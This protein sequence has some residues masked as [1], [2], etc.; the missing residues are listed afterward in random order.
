[1]SLLCYLANKLSEGSNYDR[2]YQSACIFLASC[3]WVLMLLIVWILPDN[4]PVLL[5]EPIKVMGSIFFAPLYKMLFQMDLKS[6]LVMLLVENMV[7]N[8]RLSVFGDI[9]RSCSESRFSGLR[10]QIIF[11]TLYVAFT[12]K[13]FHQCYRM[14]FRLG[15]HFSY[16]ISLLLIHRW[17]D[18]SLPQKHSLFSTKG[19]PWFWAVWQ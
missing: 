2:I 3:F 12:M 17:R 1:M 18:V 11:R 19:C 10:R 15:N 6:Y 4:P 13:A 16:T 7:R 5:R 8:C 9:S 14:L